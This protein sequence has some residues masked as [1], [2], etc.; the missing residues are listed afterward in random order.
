MLVRTTTGTTIWIERTD[1]KSMFDN[2]NTPWYRYPIADDKDHAAYR[3]SLD[4][5][6]I[7]KL[8]RTELKRICAGAS[9]IVTPIDIKEMRFY[10]KRFTEKGKWIVDGWTDFTLSQILDEANKTHKNVGEFLRQKVEDALHPPIVEQIHEERPGGAKKEASA[11]GT[12]KNTSKRRKREESTLVTTGD[13]STTLTPKQLEFME[14]LSENQDWPEN[15][16]DGSYVASYYAEELNDTMNPM[17]VGAIIT[18]LREK[19][20]LATTKVSYGGIKT[21]KFRL[22]ETGKKIYKAL[23]ERG[24]QK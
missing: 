18:T 22:T 19:G 9:S 23:S 20:L 5:S 4:E 12:T 11:A 8:T 7:I 21:C 3:D 16:V 15:G 13:V 6:S 10:S 14:R 1:G 24:G 17:S 2:N